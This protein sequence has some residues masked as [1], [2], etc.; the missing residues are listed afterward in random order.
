MLPSKTDDGG[1]GVTWTS[2]D[3]RI[4]LGGGYPPPFGKLGYALGAALLEIAARGTGRWFL[5]SLAAA[6]A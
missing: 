3:D 2:R 1:R 5:L 4:V 6:L